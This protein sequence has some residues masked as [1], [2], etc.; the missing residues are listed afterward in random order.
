MALAFLMVVHPNES[1]E[2]DI[3]MR[4][5]I[6]TSLETNLLLAVPDPSAMCS[7]AAQNRTL[8]A[9]GIEQC[10]YMSPVGAHARSLGGAAA[11]GAQ[12]TS[13][14]KNAALRRGRRAAFR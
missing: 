10:L 7:W 1:E 12:A 5:R 6:N 8:M 3:N 11:L 4:Q 2:F 14:S 13:L 9:A